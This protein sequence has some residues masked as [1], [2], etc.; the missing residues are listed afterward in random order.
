MINPISLNSKLN[1]LNSLICALT[2]RTLMFTTLHRLMFGKNHPHLQLISKIGSIGRCNLF[3]H[4]QS[5]AHVCR[6][7]WYSHPVTKGLNSLSCNYM[8]HFSQTMSRSS[9]YL[10][11][12]FPLTVQNYCMIIIILSPYNQHLNNGFRV[13]WVI[14]IIPLVRSLSIRHVACITSSF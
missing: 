8:Q 4:H 10:A 14:V 12:I 7:V 11:L 3:N 5:P 13:Q 9:S 1:W 2:A 6:I